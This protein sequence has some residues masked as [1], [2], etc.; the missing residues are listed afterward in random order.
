MGVLAGYNRGMGSPRS[1]K[2]E[3]EKSNEEEDDRGPEGR[4]QG[5]CG[6]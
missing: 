3:E 6:R 1:S 5:P 4:G 2:E